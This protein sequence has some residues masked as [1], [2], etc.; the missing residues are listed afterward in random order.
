MSKPDITDEDYEKVTEESSLKSTFLLMLSLLAM[1]FG[2]VAGVAY[3]ELAAEVGIP[4]LELLGVKNN[5]TMLCMV[6]G[7]LIAWLFIGAVLVRRLPWWAHFAEMPYHRERNLL[8]SCMA[9]VFAEAA[10]L[11]LVTILWH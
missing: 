3:Y 6:V 7:P 1:C 11:A 9:I 8:C 10:S 2:I 5:I 4:Y